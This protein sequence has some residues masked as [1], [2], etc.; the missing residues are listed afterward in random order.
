M[1]KSNVSFGCKDEHNFYTHQIYYEKKFIKLTK[2][3]EI[4]YFSANCT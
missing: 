3:R 4:C 1:K 2:I